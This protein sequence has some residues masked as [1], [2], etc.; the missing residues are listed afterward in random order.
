MT[1]LHSG[2]QR[3][4]A[5][6]EGHVK[7]ESDQSCLL[8]LEHVLHVIGFSL[9]LSFGEAEKTSSQAI[10]AIHRGSGSLVLQARTTMSELG[11]QLVCRQPRTVK[12]RSIFD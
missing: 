4:G 3:H 12:L 9:I 7:Q 8:S 10:C 2:N 11:L 6:V 5:Q 1:S